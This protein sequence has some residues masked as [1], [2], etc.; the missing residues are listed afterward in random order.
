MLIDALLPVMFYFELQQFV[1][2]CL[3]LANQYVVAVIVVFQQLQKENRSITIKITP[4]SPVKKSLSILQ[5]ERSHTDRHTHRQ[6]DSHKS[7]IAPQ[8]GR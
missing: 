8:S 1:Y 7:I 5:L 2:N 3:K 6:T 4:E